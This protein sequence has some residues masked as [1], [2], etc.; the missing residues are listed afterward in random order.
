MVINRIIEIL[1]DYLEVDTSELDGNTQ[2]YLEYDL[3][4]EDIQSFIE[5]LET[6]FDVTIDFDEFT[7]LSTIEEIAEYIE[8]FI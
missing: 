4:D 7:E 6:E 2:L 5:M 1:S 8:S 3:S